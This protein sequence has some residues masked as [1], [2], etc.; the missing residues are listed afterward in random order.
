MELSSPAEVEAV[1]R[2]ACHPYRDTVVPVSSPLLWLRSGGPL[3]RTPASPHHTL[4]PAVPE[5]VLTPAAL[6]QEIAACPTVSVVCTYSAG[7]LQALLMLVIVLD[8]SRIIPNYAC[9]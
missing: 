7:M 2:C 9:L 4:P 5:T 8:V 1:L 3:Q 6:G